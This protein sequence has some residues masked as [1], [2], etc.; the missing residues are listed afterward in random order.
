V[1]GTHSCFE[2]ES[3]GEF[4]MSVG[5]A[6]QHPV[7][8][9]A[10]GGELEAARGSDQIKRRSHSEVCHSEVWWRPTMTAMMMMM[11]M[12][13]TTTM[14]MTATA[15]QTVQGSAEESSIV[16]SPDHQA[17]GECRPVAACNTGP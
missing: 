12:M 13:S 16:P 5:H 7:E 9:M 8:Y 11:M 3:K 17:Q 2:E 15:P 1:R 4:E 14:T 6:S 10:A